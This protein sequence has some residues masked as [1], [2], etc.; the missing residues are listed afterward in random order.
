MNE[1]SRDEAFSRI[2]E[3]TQAHVR[4]YIAGMGVPSSDT[5]DIAQ[6]V[7]LELYRNLDGMPAD[8]EPIR[9]LKGIARNICLNHFR[10]ESRTKTS[11]D[12]DKLIELLDATP[13]SFDD[14]DELRH[15]MSVLS[16]CLEQLSEKNREMLM[17]RYRDDQNSERIADFFSTTAEAVRITLFRVRSKLKTC[18]SRKVEKPS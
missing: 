7:Y 14:V 1:A 12:F 18:M 15:G 2:L 8:V 3:D 6:D 11:P 13:S 5:D 9:W 4:A 16:K 17:M 10:R